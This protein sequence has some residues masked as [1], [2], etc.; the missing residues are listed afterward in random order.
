VQ[1]GEFEVEGNVDDI[2]AKNKVEAEKSSSAGAAKF[3]PALKRWVD[4]K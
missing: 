3:G 2:E 1:V 4:V